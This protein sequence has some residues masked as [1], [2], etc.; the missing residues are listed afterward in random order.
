MLQD[1]HYHL[2][3]SE[4]LPPR[5]RLLL[6][7]SGGV[8]SVVLLDLL[9]QLNDYYNWEI[10][11]AHLDH[12][13]RSDSAEDANLVAQLAD[14]RGYKF[15]L[16]QLSGNETRE[17]ALRK[18]R[19]EF[20]EAIREGGNYDFI[21]T[22]HHA[23]DRL[24]TSIFNA[25]RG[26]DRLGLSA[27]QP[28]RGEIVRPLLP[29]DKAGIIT[30]AGLHKLPYREDSTNTNMEFSRNF[31]RHE[32]MPQGSLNYRNFRRKYTTSLDKL[33]SINSRINSQLEQLLAELAL[34]RSE[35]TYEIDLG[36]WQQLSEIIK[37]YVLEYVFKQLRPGVELTQKN[38]EQAMRFF[39]SSHVGSSTHL[40]TGLH[41][42]RDY[43][44]VLITLTAPRDKVEGSDSIV[45]LRSGQIYQSGMFRLKHRI[46]PVE[47]TAPQAYTN[48]ADL[49]VRH[50]QPGDRVQPYGMS[51]SKKL[52]DVF[53]DQKVP[54]NLRRRWPVVVTADNQVVW[55]PTLA[56]DRR[57]TTDQAKQAAAQLI[58]ELV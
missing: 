1:L 10:G 17:V 3:D 23:D 25:I 12:K 9:H 58:C 31:V 46:K 28:R 47:T 19:Y 54:R 33:D 6:A 44:S 32:L 38:I 8:D 56:S 5:T 45:P 39:G 51:G 36:K 42:I 22:A 37:P 18:A 50:W 15:Y 24:E 34:Q 2:Q 57:Y 26:A 52:Q 13:V 55:V 48:T 16:G 20:L 35:V 11:V 30:Y 53:V 29:F 4:L 14:E 49:Y 40:S 27:L 41:L 43:A 21:V 7:V